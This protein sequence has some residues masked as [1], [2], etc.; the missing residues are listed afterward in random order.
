MTVRPLLPGKNNRIDCPTAPLSFRQTR[1]PSLA[2][3][4]INAPD[5]VGTNGRPYQTL[6][7][8][9]LVSD[10]LV[11]RAV[12][13]YDMMLS[14]SASEIEDVK[15]KVTFER[16]ACT[17][18]TQMRPFL[19]VLLL[20]TTRYYCASIRAVVCRFI[21][22]MWCGI[23]AA[24]RLDAGSSSTKHVTSF[25]F[26]GVLS[27]RTVNVLAVQADFVLSSALVCL[28]AAAAVLGVE[29]IVWSI[30]KWRR[31]GREDKRQPL[32]RPVPSF[33]AFLDGFRSLV[34]RRPSTVFLVSKLHHFCP[35]C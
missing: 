27:G 22:G 11:D 26:D 31:R 7:G 14:M 35:I 15:N 24:E 32:P 20:N 16:Y 23:P 34:R 18:G 12:A 19:F 9:W 10:F 5:T 30:A 6:P 13:D 29:N 21:R 25:I 33:P 4:I 17:Y 3:R 2:V 8:K 28:G 1:T